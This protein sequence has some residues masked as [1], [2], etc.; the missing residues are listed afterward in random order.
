MTLR[1]ISA[2]WFMSSLGLNISEVNIRVSVYSFYNWFQ[3]AKIFLFMRI[4]WL[5][6]TN[7]ATWHQNDLWAKVSVTTV[8]YL[9]V[10]PLS[11]FLTWEFS[12]FNKLFI[13]SYAIQDK[14]HP[15][16]ADNT[17]AQQPR[18]NGFMGSLGC[19]KRIRSI[20]SL[21]PLI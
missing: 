15:G 7:C 8:K 19:I 11:I 10:Y 13:N 9:N 21:K 2:K 5:I 12:A 17:R 1:S 16:A 14:A 3:K 4:C 20:A 6:W 18:K